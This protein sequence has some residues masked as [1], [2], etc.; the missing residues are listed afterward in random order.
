MAIQ[1]IMHIIKSQKFNISF[2]KPQSMELFC[3][4]SQFQ[5]NV[6]YFLKLYGNHTF[7]CSQLLISAISVLKSNFDFFFET[8]HNMSLVQSINDADKQQCIG[9]ASALL[10]RLLPH[11]SDDDTVARFVATLKCLL[12]ACATPLWTS[13]NSTTTPR[14]VQL[15]R[16]LDEL[17]SPAAG[18]V[19]AAMFDLQRLRRLVV[20][21]FDTMSNFVILSFI[22]VLI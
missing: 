2:V 15:L 18:S 10:E 12:G 11:A 17:L 20:L 22:L 14:C 9:Y 3:C 21:R 4:C 13:I 7:D 16:D 19:R 1:Y 8:N 6:L 5:L